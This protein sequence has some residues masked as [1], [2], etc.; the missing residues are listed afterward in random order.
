LVGIQKWPACAS[1]FKLLFAIDFTSSKVTAALNDLNQN[2]KNDDGGNHHIDHVALI[3]VANGDVT[4]AARTN[5]AR[6]C[7]ITKQRNEDDGK[8][9]NQRWQAFPQKH[10][11]DDLPSR[12]A[13]R[14]SRLNQTGVNFG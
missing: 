12:S 3:T 13:E 5:S 11:R 14:L 4:Q 2:D 9:P 8:A 7:G 10:L 1:H 6:H